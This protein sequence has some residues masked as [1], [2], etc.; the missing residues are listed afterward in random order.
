MEKFKQL[1]QILAST[2]VDAEKF[3]NS[4]NSAAGT[5]V[6]KAMQ[7]VKNLTQE[8]RK[9]VTSIKEATKAEAKVG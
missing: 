6:R 3:F 1:K 8:I 7:E 4:A 2:E 9:E 5:R